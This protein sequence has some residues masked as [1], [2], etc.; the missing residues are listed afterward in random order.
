[1]YF[2][3]V[4]LP[5][6][7]L[8]ACLSALTQTCA[9]NIPSDDFLVTEGFEV[10]LWAT[11]PQLS[12]PTNFDIDAQGRI[13]VTEALNYRNF[14]N[15]DLGL[16]SDKGDKVVVLED[17]D[18]DG[19]ADSSHTFVQDKDLVAPLGIA[20]IG[21]RV[22][23]SCAPNLIVYTDV[24]EDATFDPATDRKEILLTGFS[25]LDHDH[26]LHSVT[27]GP[28][29]YW[30][31]NTGNGGPHTVTD[32]DGWTLR[33]G[34]S[35]AGGSPHLKE[36]YPGR[37]SDDGRIWVGGVALR[38]RPDGSGLEPIG[39][40]FRNVYEESVSSYGDVF[41]A[42]NDDPPACR[43]TWLMKY[44]NA[45]FS[46]SDGKR[47]W[48]LD[49]RPDQPTRI[50][51]WRQ[52]DPGILPAGDVYGF[53]APTGV[54]YCENGCFDEIFPSGLL[55][56]CESARGELL[57]YTP[58]LQGAGFSLD[59]MTFLKVR[60]GSSSS[61][62][63]RPSDVAVGPDGAIYISDWYDPGVGGHRMRDAEGSGS[64]Y[65]IAPPMFQ[66]NIPT[67]DLISTPGQIDAIKSPAVHVRALGFESLQNQGI[68]AQEAVLALSKSTQPFFAARAAWLL[69]GCGPAGLRRLQDMLEDDS[70]QLR[71]VAFRS[72]SQAASSPTTYPAVLDAWHTARK[73]ACRDPSPAV[74]REVALSL[75]D[76]PFDESSLMISELA[77]RYDGWD[78]WYLEALGT[79]CE[80][81][82]QAAYDLL[83]GKQS[84]HPMLWDNRIAGLAWRLHPAQAVDA[85]MCRAMEQGLPLPD[86]KKMV[87][88]I[89]FIA[90]KQAAEA[91]LA[92]AEKGPEDTRNVASW[93]GNHQM[94]NKWA[95]F[96]LSRPFPK[97]SLA[98]LQKTKT[99][100][101]WTFVPNG[102]PVFESS[103]NPAI[104]DVELSDVNRLYLVVDSNERAM[105]DALW[106]SP[107]LE[108]EQKTI[109]LTGSKW[110]AAFS[111]APTTLFNNP[112]KP[113]HTPQQSKSSRP[114]LT[115]LP[116]IQTNKHGKSSF[117]V[118][119][120]AV[121]AFDIST[122]HAHRFTAHG[123][124]PDSSDSDT[125][126]QFSVYVDQS[127]AIRTPIQPTS[128]LHTKGNPT[129]GRSVFY[130]SRVGCAKCHSFAGYGGDIG[131]DL[132][133]IAKK[134][135]TEA[136]YED[137]LA[138]HAAIATGFETMTILTTR[139]T[140]L[141]GLQ[142]SAGNPVV[143]KDV[144][145][146]IHSVPREEIDDITASRNSL[147]PELGKLLTTEELAS[148]IAF[149][150]TEGVRNE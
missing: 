145:G 89:A 20:V 59:R 128:L 34:S 18:G 92:I 100:Q 70:A 5:A 67:L 73:Q 56:V 64:I 133:S 110:I 60:P 115:G 47:K 12:N 132:T 91:M 45:G 150:Q 28:D 90:T 102:K 27:V 85:L 16:A 105:T 78:R 94:H 40:N 137:I 120:R 144:D 148:L 131:P 97:T 108:T 1:M 127:P 71:L 31:F 24:N 36:N 114:P 135:S 10:Q 124:I 123:M 61:G 117:Q 33:A 43:T 30:Y 4:S 44:G 15:A 7:T 80:G 146:T 119:G 41:H 3:N 99:R 76:E 54:A 147:M 35:Y 107:M 11:S 48:Q 77:E 39:H 130:S 87:D 149:L 32:K 109:D 62:M 69:P 111:N 19:R 8:L 106:S 68:A 98:E 23:V 66:T 86:R 142:V 125:S 136:L 14:R 101:D 96:K 17:T 50:A 9:E 118:K 84:E 88:A 57:G 6:L 22:V 25:G 13:W 83:I 46:S 121:I 81:N 38:M 104:I 93:W 79:A 129:L 138:P 141:S 139:G 113:N 42:D 37:K 55:L 103:E 82:E 21:N 122:L 52:E 140:V 75:R 63:F 72:L 112:N 29:G 143:L 2:K 116:I 26:S 65:R 49:Q 53:G 95:S 74:R 51:E 126:V 58:K 134:H